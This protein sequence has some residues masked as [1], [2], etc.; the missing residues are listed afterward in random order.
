[1]KVLHITPSS[2][3]YEKVDLIANRVNKKNHLAVIKKNGEIFYTGG[4]IFP[5]NPLMRELFNNY[6]QKDHYKIASMLKN[7]P[8]EKA[9]YEED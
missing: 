5:D 8:F 1:M 6:P 7:D 4:I 3:G 9:Y 2:D